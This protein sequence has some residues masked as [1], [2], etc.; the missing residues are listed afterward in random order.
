MKNIW[1]GI[2]VQ[3]SAKQ[4]LEHIINSNKIPHS[5]LF[6]GNEGVGKDFA[7]LKF[8]EALN[9]KFS[10]SEKAERINNL[11]TSFSEPYIK[12]IIPLPRGK[13]ENDSSSPTEKL[14]ADE[15]QIL[16]EEL[17]RKSGNPYYKI[18]I[19]KANSIKINSIRDIKKF[20]SYE[21]SD[22]AYRV[23]LISGAHL[24]NEEAQNALLKSLEEPPPGVIFILTTAF[25]PMLRETIRSRCSIINFQ[26]LGYREIKNVLIE[27]FKAEPK[28]AE[29]ISPFALG[30]ILNAVNLIENDFEVLLEKTIFILRY[31]FG[32]KYHSAL[33]QFNQI[34]SDNNAETLKLVISM[35]IIW[36]NDIQKFRFGIKDFYFLDYLE[37]LEKFNKR[38]PGIPLTKIVYRLEYLSSIIQNNINLHLIALNIVY[39]LSALTSK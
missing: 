20:L 30:S 4:T 5:F 36:L 10:G 9:L 21:Y 26:P 16:H 37:T 18:S 3:E 32:K 39:E 25:P 22:I 24:M 8:T 14:S 28:L 7:A 31:S 35:I 12:Y 13:N 1:N 29:K 33:E 6:I 2:Y 27:Y 34:L 19:P 38:F 23:V 15:I 17:K 11:V